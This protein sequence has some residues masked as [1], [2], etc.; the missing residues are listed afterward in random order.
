MS[1]TKPLSLSIRF[2]CM[3]SLYNVVHRIKLLV[4]FYLVLICI[5]SAQNKYGNK[6]HIHIL[7]EVHRYTAAKQF[8]S[9]V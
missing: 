4:S 6:T 2:V 8:I 7:S 5:L 1:G 3:Y 9:A